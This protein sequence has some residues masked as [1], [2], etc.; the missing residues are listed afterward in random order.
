MQPHQT[1]LL[2]DAETDF[3]EWAQRQLA[4]ETTRVFTTTRSDE[5]LKLWSREEPDLLITETS[6]SAVELLAKCAQKLTPS[7]F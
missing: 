2:V 1:I 6:P 4:N 5:A 7:S 3:L